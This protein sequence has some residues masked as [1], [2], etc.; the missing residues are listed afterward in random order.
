MTAFG[1]M[2]GLSPR[3]P[4]ERFAKLAAEAE[5]A[6]F[7]MA[8]LGDSQLY[9]KNVYV[10]LTIAALQTRTIHVGPGVSNPVTRHFTVLANAM[11]AMQE[12]SAGR[13]VLG[14]GSGD[15]AVFPLGL[16]PASLSQLRT[17]VSG[18]RS[19]ANEGQLEVPGGKI[20]I[21]IGGARFPILISASQPAML[22]LAG[23]IADGV[24]LMG[25]ADPGLT[26]WQLDRVSEGAAAGGRSLN[27]VFVDL[28]FA[29]SM[30]E[31]IDI[32]TRE[33][34]PWATSQARWFARWKEVPQPLA[35][36]RDEF[37]RATRSHS[38]E[39]HL[40]RDSSDSADGVSPEFIRWVGVAGTPQQCF[41]KIRPLLSLKIDRITFAL[42]PGGRSERIREFS[43]LLLP[44]LASVK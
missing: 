5:E 29:I 32:A 41:D 36:W 34:R 4:I 3:E 16:P 27:D 13:A 10:A 37:E 14:L 25:A 24:I 11:S 1:F 6:G 12:V 33:V 23:E 9:T 21:P 30:R 26:Q 42:L 31:D 17:S 7:E 22:R 2:M 39:R 20:A 15:A 8:W 28:W 35:P 38:F 43:S 40:A 18:L 44:P 19:I